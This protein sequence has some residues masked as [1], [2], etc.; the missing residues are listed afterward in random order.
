MD[1]ILT[2]TGL[3]AIAASLAIFIR[4]LVLRSRCMDDEFFTHAVQYV[5]YFEPWD[6]MTQQ[7]VDEEYQEGVDQNGNPVYRTRQVLKDVVVE[8]DAYYDAVFENGNSIQITQGMYEDAGSLFGDK[9][10]FYD[11][12]RDY[13]SIDGDMWSHSWNGNPYQC[14]AI[15]LKRKYRNPVRQTR[16]LFRSE[17]ITKEDA[18]N[19][20]L[21][22]RIP[23]KNVYGAEIDSDKARYNGWISSRLTMRNGMRV[24]Y[25]FFE[26][27][28]PEIAGM[29]K[30][31]WWNGSRNEMTVCIGT[32]DNVVKWCRCFSWSNDR[33]LELMVEKQVEGLFIPDTRMTGD[34]ILENCEKWVYNDLSEYE[35]LDRNNGVIWIGVVGAVVGIVL[36]LIGLC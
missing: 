9:A 24:N 2:I 23:Y 13:H 12:R 19:E 34:F 27:K 31:Y 28:G 10:E 14:Y 1:T 35:Y 5:R 3:L 32:D 36:L 18:H 16:S 17:E 29:Q 25:L 21:Y 30:Q 22:E 20:G 4:M 7:W 15:T 6:E 11:M 26:R 33:T 8:H